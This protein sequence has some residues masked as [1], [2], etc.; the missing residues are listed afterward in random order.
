ML[1]LEQG[2]E[3]AGQRLT[4]ADQEAN[5][6]ARDLAVATPTP[7]RMPAASA[8]SAQARTPPADRLAA[9]MSAD[10][11]LATP[12]ML[13]SPATA[14][15]LGNAALLR[16]LKP[17]TLG[18][19]SAAPA[20]SST[21]A[22]PGTMV[23]TPGEP[24]PSGPLTEAALAAISADA[25]RLAREVVSTFP[26]RTRILDVFDTWDSRDRAVPG[27][28]GD[29]APHI[30]ALCAALKAHQLSATTTALDMVWH[31]IHHTSTS[32]QLFDSL[33]ARSPR[34]R[35][36]QPGPPLRN[37]WQSEAKEAD[38]LRLLVL[39]GQYDEV[40]R[41]LSA[42]FDPTNRDDITVELVTYLDD[43]TLV[44]IGGSPPGRDLLERLYDEL[45]AGKVGEDEQA[46]AKR[47]QTART[48]T[49]TPEMYQ[50][51]ITTDDL[52]VFPYR[53]GGFSASAAIPW[54]SFVGGGQIFVRRNMNVRTDPAFNQD[55]RTLPLEAFTAKGMVLAADQIVG[56]R[57]YDE[58]GRVEYVPALRLVALKNEGVTHTFIATPGIAFDVLAEP[59][60][61]IG[62]APHIF[63]DAEWAWPGDL[64]YYLEA[65]HC[66]LPS[67]FVEHV[68]LQQ[69]PPAEE[70]IDVNDLTL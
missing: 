28:S 43:A 32:G 44:T 9:G 3:P 48:A 31:V 33:V 53:K 10:E 26:N 52:R 38:R 5:S 69:R 60:T 59:Q 66:A 27:P 40:Q 47:I 8:F 49:V 68:Q 23:T 6:S 37:F 67:A 12:D 22:A 61:T 36:F 39:A 58:G 34:Y 25:D 2:P 41:R 70:R 18:T 7:D 20:A 4:G 50:K 64:A 45:T 24:S 13:L 16:L 46:Q 42:V 62:A 30:E 54:A 11:R 51:A 55:T 1:S 21:T 57:Y 17:G 65:Y 63:T 19:R 15:N 14:S 35:S 29:S 56:V